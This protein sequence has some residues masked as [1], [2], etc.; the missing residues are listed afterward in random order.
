[1]SS[2][3]GI[4]VTYNN[5]WDVAFELMKAVATVL[6]CAQKY[7]VSLSTITMMTLFP[8]DFGNPVMKSMETSSQR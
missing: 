8:S 5:L 1:M 2:E 4:S 7:L 6:K 3:Y